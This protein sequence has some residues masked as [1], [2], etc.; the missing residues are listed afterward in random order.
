[1]YHQVGVSEESR[2]IT[3]FRAPSGLY[4]YKRLIQG[5]SALPEIYNNIIE[6]KVVNGIKDA[7]NIFDDI[8]VT[9]DDKMMMIVI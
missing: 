8:L 9:F 2:H 1:M 7:R 5:N 3:I 4:R 6:T